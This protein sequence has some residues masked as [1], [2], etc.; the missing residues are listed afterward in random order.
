MN[1]NERVK[2]YLDIVKM[3][4]KT[5]REYLLFLQALENNNWSQLYNNNV[6][7]Y[8][9]EILKPNDA[10]FALNYTLFSSNV[11]RARIIDIKKDLVGESGIKVEGD[12]FYGFRE[13]ESREPPLKISSEGRNNI[14]G[15]SYFYCAED[16]YTA[17]AELKPSSKCFISLAKFQVTA[18]LKLID[19]SENKFL[20][21][22]IDMSS[23]MIITQMM[24]EFF[25]TTGN[26]LLTQVLSDEIRKA[27]YDGL[28]YVSARSGGKNITI[29]CP[30]QNNL[31][32]LGSKV[33]FVSPAIYRII[34]LSKSKEMFEND[35]NVVYYRCYDKN[36]IESIK[37]EFKRSINKKK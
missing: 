18:K 35:N 8:F 17:C 6:Y 28:R 20:P 11:Y 16:E 5:E 30:N 12:V 21:K 26:Y 31:K 10:N 37:K 32:F 19:F 29:F 9:K 36:Q 13:G 22:A 4:Y 24:K 25:D 2:E 14:C 27:G 34:D 15:A 33:M 23:G 3:K 7:N 1:D